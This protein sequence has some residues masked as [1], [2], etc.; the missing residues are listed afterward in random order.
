MNNILQTLYKR[1]NQFG[2]YYD[3]I[4]V[5]NLFWM[6]KI[7]KK[8]KEYSVNVERE[9]MDFM[10]KNIQEKTKNYQELSNENE[11]VQPKSIFIR[12]YILNII[13]HSIPK[14]FYKIID[15]NADSIVEISLAITLHY[16]VLQ[17]YMYS[18]K[19]MSETEKKNIIGRTDFYFTINDIQKVRGKTSKEEL[20]KYL[21]IFAKDIT[22]ISEKDKMGLFLDE[23]IP[24]LICI[25]EFLD[26]LIFQLEDYFRANTSNIDYSRYTDKKGEAFEQMV[27]EI[28][29]EMFQESYHTLYYFPNKNQKMESDVLIRDEDNVAIIECKSG[30]FNVANLNDDDLIKLQIRNKTKKAYKTLK[31][32]IKYL[33]N[34]KEYYFKCED[35]IITG[36]VENPI[37]IHL[38]MYSM[39][40]I[41]SNIHVM[42]PEYFENKNPILSM[43]IEHFFA[44]IFDAKINNKDIF[45]YWKKRKRDIQEYPEIYFDNNEL[46][47]YYEIVNEDDNTMLAELKR[48]GIL[49]QLAPN[50]K[51]MSTF[52]N[53]LG[54]EVRPAQSMLKRLDFFLLT[55]ILEKG[56]SWFNINKRYL[57]N[58]EEYLRVS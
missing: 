10:R 14:E 17:M 53:E 54:K 19:D 47:L 42:F 16:F 33:E 20:K 55:C 41:A 11:F 21:D 37:S 15:Y 9:I 12:I 4:T 51:I 1:Y 26:Y 45:V 31:Q 57:K 38:S 22:D 52:H 5:P 13:A 39:D 18:E 3:S 44:M 6:I 27:Y 35:G 48:Q 50:A 58:L 40:F 36:Q 7:Y 43:S 32:V 46:D 24:F 2:E 29:K 25:E 56:K 30:T 8:S 23:G 49:E 34:T 28:T